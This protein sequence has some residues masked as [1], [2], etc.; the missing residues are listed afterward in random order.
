MILLTFDYPMKKY[1]YYHLYLSLTL[2]TG[3]VRTGM[4]HSL[5]DS[6]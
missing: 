4:R 1:G 5:P 3:K 6:I 2:W